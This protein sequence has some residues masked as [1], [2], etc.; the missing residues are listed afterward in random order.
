[1]KPHL[2][3]FS[4]K[5]HSGVFL[6]L[7]LSLCYHQFYYYLT[8]FNFAGIYFG[9]RF[10]SFEGANENVWHVL[11]VQPNS[12]ASLAGL[13]SDT[14]YIIGADSILHEVGIRNLRSQ[15]DL[16]PRVMS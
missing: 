13:R 7:F 16:F 4:R 10:C 2:G 15:V 6:H 5:G 8:K 1:M 11:D 3:K 12:P 9:R 14:D